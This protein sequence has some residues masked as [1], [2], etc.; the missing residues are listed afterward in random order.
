M[1]FLLALVIGFLPPPV[2]KVHDRNF[3]DVLAARSG[4]ALYTWDNEKDGQVRCIDDCAKAWPPL[5]FRKT[6][7]ARHVSGIHGTFAT[8]S[9]P[10]GTTQVTFNGQPVYTYAGDA[11]GRILCDN[12]DGWH[13]VRL[14]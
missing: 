3:G 5:T 13:V 1:A 6:R 14:R 9:R 8:V 12:E 11:R 4:L 7:V 10:D 2:T